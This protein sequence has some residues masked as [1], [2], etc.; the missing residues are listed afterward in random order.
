MALQGGIDNREIDVSKAIV[1]CRSN[2]QCNILTVAST[3]SWAVTN[4]RSVMNK[5]AE[6]HL[7]L[8]TYNLD[9]LCVTGLYNYRVYLL[10]V[11]PIV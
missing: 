10:L 1:D 5:L 7:F 2:I 8:Q 4:A 11:H 6:L 3:L 9:L